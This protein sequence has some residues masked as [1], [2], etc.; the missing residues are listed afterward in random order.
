VEIRNTIIHPEYDISR[1]DFDVLIYE[2]E[3]E[4]DDYPPITIEREEINEGVFTVVGF[5][6]TDEGTPLELSFKLKEVELEYVDN[7]TCDE[8]HGGNGEV[9]EDMMCVAA[10]DKDS[11]I[12]KYLIT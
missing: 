7:D 3:E 8:G 4:I 12:G 1:F 2:L 9:M 6:D 5:G 10:E 11:C